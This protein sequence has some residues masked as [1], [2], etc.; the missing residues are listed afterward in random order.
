[1][2]TNVFGVA[3]FKYLRVTGLLYSE[4]LSFSTVTNFI[5]NSSP[6]YSIIYWLNSSNTVTGAHA[7]V[8]DGYYKD[9]YSNTEQISYM[10][11]W[12]T[13][14]YTV[15]YSNFAYESGVQKWASGISNIKR[16]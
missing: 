12:D 5:T 10:N 7:V 14:H 3:S 15:D 8:I 13:C 4:A 16:N 1:L 9:E 2:S 6:I 11:P